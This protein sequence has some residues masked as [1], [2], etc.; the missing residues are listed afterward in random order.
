MVILCFSLPGAHPPMT[1]VPWLTAA[2][3]TDQLKVTP[4]SPN[5]LPTLFSVWPPHTKP[6]FSPTT[7]ESNFGLRG[8]ILLSAPPPRQ[9][10]CSRRMLKMCGVSI[11]VD[12]LLGIWASFEDTHWSRSEHGMHRVVIHGPCSV[13]CLHPA[14]HR[15]LYLYNA[16]R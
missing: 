2:T 3:M 8:S 14:L 15:W 16:V 9:R 10:A 7:I 5:A 12:L 4:C 6:C 1:C 13:R 11:C